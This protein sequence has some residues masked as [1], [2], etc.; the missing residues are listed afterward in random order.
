MIGVIDLW[1]LAHP[2]FV[3]AM[4]SV[5]RG[6]PTVPSAGTIDH[7][8]VGDTLAG[9]GRAIDDHSADVASL[10]NR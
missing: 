8:L 6:R 4:F 1:A 5:R 3:A 10:A 9:G 2:S 7:G